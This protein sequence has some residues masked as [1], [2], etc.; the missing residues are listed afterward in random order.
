MLEESKKGCLI[1]L[2][3]IA[4][5]DG[6]FHPNEEKWIQVFIR[7]ADVDPGD[8]TVWFEELERGGVVWQPIADRGD[9]RDLLKIAV[10]VIGADGKLDERERTAL[11]QLGK[12]LGF[13]I[14]EVA[15]ILSA[16]WGRNVMLD[17]FP[18]RTIPPPP[19]AY[20][21]VT[22]D[23]SAIGRFKAVTHGIDFEERAYEEL[24]RQTGEPAVVVLHAADD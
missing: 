18:T 23:F 5:C 2:W 4:F 12:A 16:S 15:Q 17:V 19:G 24:L 10:G 11:F 22:D 1:N 20:V 3:L 7:E 13:E 8:A 21:I 14:D 9:A 6:E